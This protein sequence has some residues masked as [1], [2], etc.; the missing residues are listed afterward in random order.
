MIGHN[1]MT[2]DEWLNVILTSGEVTRIAQH[3]ALVIYH[4]SDPTTNEAKVSARDLERITGWGRTAIIDHVSELEIFIR[5]RWGAGRAKARFELQGVIADAVKPLQEARQADTTADTRTAFNSYVREADTTVDTTA[6]INS[7]VREADAN[8]ATN[9]LNNVLVSTSRTQRGGKGGRLEL[10]SLRPPENARE[11]EGVREVEG[12][13]P[14]FIVHPDGSI[15]LTAF[16]GFT[17]TEVAGFRTTYAWL[18]FPAELI[19]A[20]QRLAA[21]F[22]RDGTTFG[23]QDRIG[24]LHRMLAENNREA[25]ALVRVAQ[26]KLRAKQSLADESC[27]FDED[28]LMVAN[29]FKSDLLELVGGSEQRLRINLD[30]AA[31][32]VPIDLRGPALRKVVRG[33]FARY[34][35]WQAQDERKVAAVE[36]RLAPGSSEPGSK[37]ETAQEKWARMRAAK[38]GETT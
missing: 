2:R 18:E 36:K 30:K 29:G 7:C 13:A 34:A 15:S 10:N 28:R 33:Q 24:R 31:A 27:W 19:A 3:I 26:E 8:T 14:A 11:R 23:A 38:N 5:V 16:E 9:E 37:A 25:G 4:L 1:G 17:A 35:D 20:D 6:D 21:E 32:S 12:E 22:E